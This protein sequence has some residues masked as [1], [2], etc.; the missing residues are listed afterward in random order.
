MAPET[1]ERRGFTVTELPGQS[2]YK[3]VSA[4]RGT[5]LANPNDVYIGRALIRYGEF[6]ELEWQVIDRLTPVGATV[7]EVGANIGAHTVSLANKVGRQGFVY[8]FEPQPIVFQNLCANLALNGLTNV[9]AV[10]AGCAAHVSEIL[11]PHI[12][13][14]EH[15]NFGAISLAEVAKRQDG[16][17][18]VPIV[19]LD[20]A[21]PVGALSLIKIDAEGMETPVIKGATGLIRRFRP[22]LYVENDR[23]EKSEELIALLFELGYRAW[24]HLPKYFNT[25][26]IAEEAENI[27]GRAFSVNMICAPKGANVNM[28]RLREVANPREHPLAEM[29]K[30][31]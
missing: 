8:A 10:N 1:I 29:V 27:Y 22:V 21:C 24:W 17:I 7:I 2:L 19:D 20:S 15:G 6:S 26:N 14:A 16:C 31:K 13:Y 5:F 30:K 9:Q 25:E 23:L 11:F 4:R 18:K 12:N 28:G 3:L